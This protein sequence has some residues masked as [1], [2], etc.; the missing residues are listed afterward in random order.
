MIKHAFVRQRV[1]ASVAS[2]ASSFVY[3]KLQSCSNVLGIAQLKF[4]FRN[5]HN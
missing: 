3:L 5:A 2:T 1:G 4:G